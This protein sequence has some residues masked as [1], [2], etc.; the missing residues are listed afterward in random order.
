VST[1]GCFD[2]INHPVDKVGKVTVRVGGHAASPLDGTCYVNRTGTNHA[3]MGLPL[4]VGKS[5]KPGNRPPHLRLIG[6]R[7]GCTDTLSS[8][9]LAKLEGG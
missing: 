7:S 9:S 8:L 4:E 5:T 3:G 1:D 6:F 2:Q